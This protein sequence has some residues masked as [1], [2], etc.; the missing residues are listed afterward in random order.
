MNARVGRV[1]VPVPSRPSRLIATASDDALMP[2]KRTKSK[3]RRADP[4]KV[5]A[6]LQEQQERERRAFRKV[7]DSLRTAAPLLRA[8]GCLRILGRTTRRMG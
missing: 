1:V 5:L 8:E 7:V 3:I 4:T 6:A 2:K